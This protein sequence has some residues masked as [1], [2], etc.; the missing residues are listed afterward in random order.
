MKLQSLESK[1]QIIELPNE[2]IREINRQLELIC[3]KAGEVQINFNLRDGKIVVH[4]VENC[5]PDINS[6]LK[7]ITESI[8]QN[9]R[10]ALVGFEI[11]D[12]YVWTH[13]ASEMDAEQH[14]ITLG[15]E[16]NTYHTEIF[17][18]IPQTEY[19]TGS[20]EISGKVNFEELSAVKLDREVAKATMNNKVTKHTVPPN[21]VAVFNGQAVWKTQG[22][23]AVN[24]Y[25]SISS[26]YLSLSQN[27]GSNS[28]ASTP[29][30]ED[31]K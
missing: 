7:S 11:Q 2:I 5:T 12:G 3:D 9:I 28:V 13:A 24:E 8:V 23:D 16:E 10:T 6:L 30:G 27:R 15:G 25:G 19:V 26:V 1:V 22:Y 21:S 4:D 31:S 29:S 18:T 17:S 20:I 14:W